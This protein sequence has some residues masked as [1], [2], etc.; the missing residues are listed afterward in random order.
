MTVTFDPETHQKVT[1]GP[2]K[3]IELVNHLHSLV[4]WIKEHYEKSNKEWHPVSALR[5][6]TD[7]VKN[8]IYTYGVSRITLENPKHSREELLFR[9]ANNKTLVQLP[10]G[11]SE[12]LLN[13]AL[14]R[15]TSWISTNGYEEAIHSLKDVLG[16]LNQDAK[17]CEQN[18]IE[19]L[20]LKTQSR[21]IQ[22]S[23]HF[24]R[25]IENLKKRLEETL[26]K[27]GIENQRNI[28]SIETRIKNLTEALNNEL[29]I[30]DGSDEVNMRFRNVACGLILVDQ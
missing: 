24:G 7:L 5:L 9:V 2:H 10:S 17:K 6:K 25:K 28:K 19:E 3:N 15:G 16:Q 4:A 30:L 29:L 23:N 12:A 13:Q 20:E 27:Q 22:A 18:F 11:E 1:S 8:G 21:R 26:N 14:D